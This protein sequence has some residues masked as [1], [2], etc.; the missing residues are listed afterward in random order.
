MHCRC[1]HLNFSRHLSISAR[2]Y[3]NSDGASLVS[4]RESGL[5]Q[6]P[7][8]LA[9]ATGA[10]NSITM[11]PS[12]SLCGDGAIYVGITGVDGGWVEDDDVYGCNSGGNV[13]YCKQTQRPGRLSIETNKRPDR[14][15]RP[16]DLFS[17]SRD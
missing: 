4:P 12:R 17:V 7:S 13:R 9:F 3:W 14:S 10:G 6:I 5:R 11:V 1:L 16:F 2:L 8:Q 15:I